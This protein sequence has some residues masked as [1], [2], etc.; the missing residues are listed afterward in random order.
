[1]TFGDGVLGAVAGG[2][3]G[4]LSASVTKVGK[5]EFKEALQRIDSLEIKLSE[6]MTRTEFEQSFSK[7]ERLVWDFRSEARAEFK[8]LKSELKTK[9]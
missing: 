9:T 8:E 7:V 4:W 6:R 2:L 3:V 1:M 5:P